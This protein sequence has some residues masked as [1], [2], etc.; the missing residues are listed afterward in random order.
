MVRINNKASEEITIKRGTLWFVG[1]A[2]VLAGVVFSYGSSAISWVRTDESRNVRMAVIEQ[3]INEMN[4]KIDAMSDSAITQRLKDA[5]M[6][7]FNAGINAAGKEN[8]GK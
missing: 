3:K 5:E 7:G 1:T 8:N 4:A 6:R 2:L